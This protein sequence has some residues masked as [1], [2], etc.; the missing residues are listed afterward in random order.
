[1]LTIGLTGGIGSGK[2][3]VSDIFQSL[4]VP[5]IDSDLIAHE[6]VQPGEPGLKGI[7]QHFG[8]GILQPDG[9]LNRQQ[10]RN[11]VFNDET[12]RKQLEQMLHPLIR[13]QS[14][15]QLAALNTPYAILA[16]PLLV[17]TGLTDSV[18]RVLVVDCPEPLQIERICSRDSINHDQATAILAAQ[19]SRKQRLKAADDII[20]NNQPI[21]DLTK[22]VKSLHE[23]YLSISTTN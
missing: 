7:I 4:G 6:V 3:T 8:T 9:S 11:L 1:M 18:D 2:S 17:E 22:R 23:Q 19:C 15:Q 21:A 12:A 16:I 14:Q 5:V 10:L 20:N 13:Q